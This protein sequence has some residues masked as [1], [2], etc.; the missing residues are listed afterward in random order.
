MKINK[1]S[2]SCV[3]VD[4]N[5]NAD[6]NVNVNVNVDIN[7]NVKPGLLHLLIIYL[8]LLIEHSGK[9]MKP[10]AVKIAQEVS[11]DSLATRTAGMHTYVH[12][13]FVVL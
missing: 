1:V 8:Q 6:I 5:V 3:D 2:F 11:L 10:G 12:T 13:K 4:V 7:V 9:G